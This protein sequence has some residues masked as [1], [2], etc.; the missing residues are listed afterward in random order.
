MQIDGN[1]KKIQLSGN[2]EKQELQEMIT[3]LLE[4]QGNPDYK[5]NAGSKLLTKNLLFRNVNRC[6]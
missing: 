3:S 6:S 5:M 4:I 2:I 1:D